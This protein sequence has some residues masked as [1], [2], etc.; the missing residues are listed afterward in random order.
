MENLLKIENLK[1]AFHGPFGQSAC[2]PGRGLFGG[3][4]RDGGPGGRI[5]LRQDRPLPLDFDASQPARRY[6]RG[7]NLTGRKGRDWTHGKRAGVCAWKRCR[8]GLSGP[9]VLSQSHILYRQPDH[10]PMRIHRKKSG[11]GKREKRLCGFW[12]WWVSTTL[13]RVFLSTRTTFP[14]ACGRGSPSP[15]PLPVTHA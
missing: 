12:N 8:H 4:G 3:C 6:R 2:R 10:S 1:L 11:A 15:S 5:R 9:H 13:R 14:A 7:E